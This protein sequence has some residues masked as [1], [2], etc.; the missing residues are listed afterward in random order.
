MQSTVF[1]MFLD[2]YNKKPVENQRSIEIYARKYFCFSSFVTEMQKFTDDI[3]STNAQSTS[4]EIYNDVFSS[5]DR[6]KKQQTNYLLSRE[7]KLKYSS[8]HSNRQQQQQQR[9]QNET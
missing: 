4:R 7:R 3:K 9:R 6:Y 1:F 5:F 8:L 2:P